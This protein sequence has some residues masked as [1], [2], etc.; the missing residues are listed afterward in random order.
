MTINELPTDVNSAQLITAS[1][2]RLE[3]LPQKGDSAPRV[4]AV[5]T[6][7]GVYINTSA[8]TDPV[9]KGGVETQL[10]C[11]QL[12]C[13]PGSQITELP[14]P[15]NV[16]PNPLYDGWFTII[17]PT[18]RTAYDLWRARRMPDGGISYQYMRTWNLR[19]DGY[20]APGQSS[21]RGSGLPLFA[22][23]IRPAELASG[24][25]EH[26]LAISVPSAAPCY[27]VQPAS[28]TDGSGP[29]DALPEGARLRSLQLESETLGLR[30]KANVKLPAKLTPQEK[31]SASALLWTL[32]NYGAI[33]VGQAAVP[34]LYAQGEVTASLLK[35]SELQ[36]MR[37]S[38]FEVVQLPSADR[39]PWS[40]P[41]APA[42][43]CPASGA[44]L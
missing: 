8:W 34:T 10:H 19:G 43:G 18:G 36:W 35:G 38:D 29:A 1:M 23:S 26:A 42:S 11:R 20:G 44:N 15:R 16:S 17:S 14:V 24:L 13:G 41:E 22:G 4:R 30:L 25:I 9:V 21:A 7:A 3:A 6:T 28:T 12:D 39:D 40:A 27:Y 32:R 31:R 5:A 33:V 37:L 2:K